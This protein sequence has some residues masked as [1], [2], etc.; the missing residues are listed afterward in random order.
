MTHC[1]LTYG[2]PLHVLTDNG[3]QFI[4]K[5]TQE[6]CRVVGSKLSTTTTYHPQTNGQTEQ[7]NRTT[8]PAIRTYLADHPRDLDLY[9][10]ALTFA[11]NTQIHSATGQRPFDLIL[12]RPPKH[13]SMGAVYEADATSHKTERM[14]WLKRLE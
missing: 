1:V 8:L 7:F 10:G 3:S 13:F 5:F 9:T 14:K 4:A 2:Q 12:S 6:V 11:Y